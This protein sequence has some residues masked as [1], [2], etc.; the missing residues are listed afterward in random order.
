[1][2]LRIF[3]AGGA[4]RFHGDVI[5]RIVLRGPQL[6]PQAV[7]LHAIHRAGEARMHDGI[8]F[9]V[10]RSRGEQV[11]DVVTA[12]QLGAD[13]GPLRLSRVHA[14][15]VPAPEGP[16]ADALAEITGQPRSAQSLVRRL[17]RG[18]RERPA[19]GQRLDALLEANLRE[20]GFGG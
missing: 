4:I 8:A 2:L 13:D 14:T 11:R 16:L 6:I 9:R 1:M 17:R 7:R 19:E 12:E 5:G 3:T 18:L 20:L 10:E 15:G